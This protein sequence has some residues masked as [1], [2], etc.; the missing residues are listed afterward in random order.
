VDAYYPLTSLATPTQADLVAAWTAAPASIEVSLATDGKAIV[1]FLHDLA[2]LHGKPLMLSEVGYRS[3]DGAA[4]EPG[5]WT[6]TGIANAIL[7][8]DLY[9]AL[10]EVWGQYGGDWFLGI[11]LWNWE[12]PASADQ[13]IGYTPQGKPAFQVVEDWL[14][15]RIPAAGRSVEGTQSANVIDGGLGADILR[16]GAG[17]D[18][19]RGG[20]GDDLLCGG[21]NVIAPLEFTTI[22]VSARGDLVGGVGARSSF[23]STGCRSARCSRRA[24]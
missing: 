14:G 16:G 10:F 2:V 9:K 1:N 12:P 18:V 20:A 8:A 6:T 22:T 23:S 15:G 24:R 17:D 13:P 11:Q 21:P 4:T 7:Q 3:L 5:T 19:L